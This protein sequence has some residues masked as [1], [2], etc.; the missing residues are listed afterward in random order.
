MPLTNCPIYKELY[1]FLCVVLY[2]LFDNNTTK[3]D[4]QTISLSMTEAIINKANNNKENADNET[5]ILIDC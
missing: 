2:Y 3:K 5:P 1:I 4:Y